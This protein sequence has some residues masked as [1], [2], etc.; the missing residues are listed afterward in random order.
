MSNFKLTD[1]AKQIL[2]MALTFANDEGVMQ[3]KDILIQQINNGKI[4]STY[5]LT[6][7]Y[8]YIKIA[9]D[10]HCER[11]KSWIHDTKRQG[12]YQRKQK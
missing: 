6:T 7:Y 9:L 3:N 12:G 1:R 5:D 8:V 4:N 10:K 2:I 11:L